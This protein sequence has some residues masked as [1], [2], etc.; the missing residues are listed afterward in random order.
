MLLVNSVAGSNV[1]SAPPAL[2]QAEM[3]LRRD[4]LGDLGRICSRAGEREHDVDG[5][6]ADRRELGGVAAGCGR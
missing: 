6:K 5:R 1:P 2:D 3:A 4:D